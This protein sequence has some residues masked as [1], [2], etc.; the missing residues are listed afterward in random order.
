MRTKP[1]Q[2]YLEEEVMAA[3]PLQLVRLL[4]RGALDSITAARRHLR[5][6]EIRSRSNAIGKAMAIVT[7]LSRSLDPGMN[8]ELSQNLTE[9]Y[10]YVEGLLMEANLRQSDAPLAEAETLLSTLLEAWEHCANK[11]EVRGSH[12]S[13]MSPEGEPVSCAY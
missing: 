11:D 6:G 3:N 4:Y 13:T 1:H 9:L 12:V 2:N 10:S 8:G 7:E 5:L